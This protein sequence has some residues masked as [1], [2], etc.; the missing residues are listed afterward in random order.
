MGLYSMGPALHWIAPDMAQWYLKRRRRAVGK[1]YICRASCIYTTV[2]VGPCIIYK[3][4][5]EY[6]SLCA[7]P[8]ILNMVESVIQSFNTWEEKEKELH[9][10]YLVKK[11]NEIVV[12]SIQ[13]ERQINRELFFNAARQLVTLNHQADDETRNK[14][15]EFASTKPYLT[16]LR[17]KLFK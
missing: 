5:L 13:E 11:G 4:N 15:I 1:A 2:R 16:H 12:E 9:D 6:K 14:L 7:L 3:Y 8:E 10:L 17:I